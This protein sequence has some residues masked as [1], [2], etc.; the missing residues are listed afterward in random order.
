MPTAIRSSVLMSSPRTISPDTACEALTT[1]PTS[2]CSTGA[3]RRRRGNG[4]A[5]AQPWVALVELLH[6][7]E[8]PQR[9]KQLRI[10][11]MGARGG[12]GPAA[13]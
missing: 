9:A 6:L 3:D 2:S 12:R 1:V 10:H 8:R 4:A 13:M 5:F 11:Q 7:A